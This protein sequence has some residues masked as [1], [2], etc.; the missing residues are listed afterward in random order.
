MLSW[1]T[2]LIEIVFAF[3]LLSGCYWWVGNHAVENYKDQQKI[4]QADADRKQQIEWNKLSGE[5]DALKTKRQENAIIRERKIE[6]I[7]ERPV[8]IHDCFDDDGLRELNNAITNT[9]SSEAEVP[10]NTT[11]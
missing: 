1:Q 10:A 11:H 8:Y 2:K 3:L 5:L 9:R 6:K 7:V 4:E